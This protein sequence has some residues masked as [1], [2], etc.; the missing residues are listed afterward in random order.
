MKARARLFPRCLFQ[1]ESVFKGYF[2]TRM[3]NRFRRL[4]FAIA[5]VVR[6][7]K[8]HCFVGKHYR[9]VHALLRRFDD[10]FGNYLAH[11]AGIACSG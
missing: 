11:R 6:D 5:R 9:V 7:K 1:Q 2:T 10:M 4:G 8:M 3:L